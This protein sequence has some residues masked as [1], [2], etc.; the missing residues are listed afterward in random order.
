MA[1]AELHSIVVPIYNEEDV[2]RELHARLSSALSELPAYEVILVDDGSSDATAAMLAEISAGDAR[3]KC[4]S[5]ARNFGQQTAM[6]A[7]IDFARGDTVTVID[8]DL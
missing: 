3:W 5:L 6:T 7:G 2:L 1:L 8:A 4:V